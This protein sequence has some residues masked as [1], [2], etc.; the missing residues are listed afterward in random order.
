MLKKYLSPLL[1][2]A[3]VLLVGFVVLDFAYFSFQTA[4]VFD[5]KTTTYFSPGQK[6]SAPNLAPN[7][8]A[9][10]D[11]AIHAPILYPAK[12]S[13]GDYEA[14]L[15]LG[16]VH[17]PGTALPG[18]VGNCYIFGHSSDYIWVKGNYKTVFAPLTQIA[19]GDTISVSNAAGQTFNYTVTKTFITSPND[20]SVL[21]QQTNT[22]KLLTLQTSYPL[23]TALERFIVQAGMEN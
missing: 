18:A 10:S 20:L 3:A 4:R 9:I 15:K 12:N 5:G 8:I 11:L 19:I 2:S 17:F 22:K 7:Q 13:S 16:V 23:G 6:P 14:F 1:W 21:S